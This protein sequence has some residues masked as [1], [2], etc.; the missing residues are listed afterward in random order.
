MRTPIA[1][2]VSVANGEVTK[3]LPV[4]GTD[5]TDGTA[6]LNVAAAVTAPTGGFAI[7]T[8]GNLAA[9]KTALTADP[10]Q[11]INIAANATLNVKTT[12]GRVYSLYC[13]NSNASRRYLQL[14]KTATV[15]ADQAVPWK[16]FPVEAGLFSLI[17][18][19]FFTANGLAFTTGLAFAFSTTRDTYTAGSAGDQQTQ[20]NYV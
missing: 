7:E 18:V 12:A 10:L 16:C 19:D 15:P 20:I 14:H 11:F 2:A 6:S 4:K 5:N 17:G 3:V 8:G 13:H 1:A 9:L